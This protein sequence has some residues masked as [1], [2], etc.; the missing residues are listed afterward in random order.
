V[1]AGRIH[2][3]AHDLAPLRPDVG[4]DAGQPGGAVDVDR[5]LVPAAPGVESGMKRWSRY[6][7]NQS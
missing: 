1:T 5:V 3:Q 4:E 7:I 6:G 2:A